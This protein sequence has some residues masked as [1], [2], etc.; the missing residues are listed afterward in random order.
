MG[1]ARGA[2]GSA[3]TSIRAGGKAF[4]AFVWTDFT[5]LAAEL[6][7]DVLPAEVAGDSTGADFAEV[8]SS[9]CA[10][11]GKSFMIESLYC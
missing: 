4:F 8:P 7:L 3:F 5:G 2:I 1:F 11:F 9:L 6:E 10:I